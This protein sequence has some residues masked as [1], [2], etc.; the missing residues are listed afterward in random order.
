MEIQGLGFLPLLWV[1]WNLLG[2]S[3]VVTLTIALGHNRQPFISDTA[4]G[5]PEWIIY[6]VVFFGA[7]IIGV[8]VAYLQYRFMFL[9]SEPSAKHFRIYQKILFTLGCIVCIGTALNG[10]FTMGNNPTIHRISSGMAFF[11]GAIYNMC[12][13]GFLY[14]RS[15]SSRI[16]CHI[17]LA[18]TLVTSVVL[19]LFS[20]GQVS[21]YMEL[22][23]GHCEA[24]IYV[25][26][27][28]AEYL[29]FC[30]VT[31]YQV[32]SYT[33]FQHLSLKISRN[34]INVS[35]RTKIPDPEQNP[36]VE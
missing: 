3:T 22:C 2:L 17:R 12:Q 13:A 21:F 11:C 5:H 14:K 32:T 10:I 20:A 19:L 16:L 25:P 1:T 26:V 34:D 31:L 33:D 29:G 8:A 28:V 6:K 18:S 36:P 27:L 24:I 7:P 35:L 9:R 15:Y 4:V 30:G 23:I